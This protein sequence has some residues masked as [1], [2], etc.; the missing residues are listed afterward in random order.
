[1][2]FLAHMKMEIDLKTLGGDIEAIWGEN[3]RQLKTVKTFRDIQRHWRHWRLWETLWETLGR[4]CGTWGDIE[5][6]RGQIHN[7]TFF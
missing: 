1:M 2:L 5:G 7:N 3:W 4:H 6:W